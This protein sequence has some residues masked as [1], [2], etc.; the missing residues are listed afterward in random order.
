[1]RIRIRTLTVG[2][3]VLGMTAAGLS[4]AS[5]QTADARAIG[6]S[7]VFV[8]TAAVTGGIGAPVCTTALTPQVLCTSAAGQGWSFTGDSTAANQ[9]AVGLACGWLITEEHKGIPGGF[10]WSTEIKRFCTAGGGAAGQ[11]VGTATIT[12][13]GTLTAGTTGLGAYCG[14]SG[15]TGGTGSAS[16]TGPNVGGTASATSDTTGSTGTSTSVEPLTAT[17]TLSL[18]GVGWAQSAATVIV[19]TGTATSTVYIP[20][21][22]GPIVAV[23]SA[24]PTTGSCTDRTATGFTVVGAAAA[25]LTS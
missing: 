19:A 4:P 16:I 18:S 8:G 6:A 9:A 14:A 12:A 24:I 22:T 23:V 17:R 13:S 2:L 1:M 20:N 15:G 5:A 25:A 10:L 21:P 7:A 11:G 3:M